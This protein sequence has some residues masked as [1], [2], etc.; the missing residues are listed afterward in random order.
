MSPSLAKAHGYSKDEINAMRLRQLMTPESYSRLE[1][2]FGEDITEETLSKTIPLLS[3]PI[4]IEFIRKDGTTFWSENK[5]AIV[6]DAQGKPEGIIGLGRDIS[7]RKESQK[8]LID[9][10]AKYRS[11]FENVLDGVC[12]TTPDG[13]F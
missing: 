3:R 11:L 6:N 5:L 13:L 1:Q 12:R 10:D 7:E 2:I 4:E 8:A 9:S